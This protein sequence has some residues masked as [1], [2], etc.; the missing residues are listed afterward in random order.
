M[1]DIDSKSRIPDALSLSA[2]A[3][4]LMRDKQI[5]PICVGG[6]RFI[7]YQFGIR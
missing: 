3:D 6:I 1:G 2:S 7:W 4:R 5:P